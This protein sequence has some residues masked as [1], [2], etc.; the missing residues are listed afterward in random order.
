M[1]YLMASHRTE[2][3]MGYQMAHI[4]FLSLEIWNTY[5]MVVTLFSDLGSFTGHIW[6]YH[7]KHDGILE[8]FAGVGFVLLPWWYIYIK[9][10]LVHAKSEEIAAW[11]SNPLDDK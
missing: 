11:K 3:C 9:L 8:K 4:I 1:D 10:Q 2:T 6:Y 7:N 5:I